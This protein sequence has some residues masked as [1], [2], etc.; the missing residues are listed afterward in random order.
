MNQQKI[1]YVYLIVEL[2]PN[3]Q[4]TGL[5]KIVKTLS[6]PEEIRALLRTSSTVELLE[7]CHSI[8][9]LNSSNVEKYLHHKFK[10]FRSKRKGKE[11]FNF[12]N[13]N[14]HDVVK[15]MN[16]YVENSAPPEPGDS[17][18]NPIGLIL[19]VLGV[20]GIVS[21]NNQ[22]SLT[23]DQRNYYA[24]WNVFSRKN[25]D[26]FEQYTQAQEK[27]KK[28]ADSSS[29]ECVKKYGEDMVAVISESKN[30]LRSTGGNYRQ[31]WKRFEVLRKQVWPKQPVC[32]KIMTGI[33][34][35]IN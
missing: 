27:F 6:R 29:N 33:H 30:F 8:P 35:K 22:P 25:M 9:C 15:E 21:I 16:S 11:W 5:Y 7:V 4:P 28:L 26:A 19:L 20:L 12:K 10:D 17:K 18:G 24:A 13:Y 3:R 2:Q 14:I 1:G 23:K 32:N 34:Q 31:A